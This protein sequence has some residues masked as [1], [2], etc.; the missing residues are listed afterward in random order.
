MAIL[1]IDNVK[2]GMV[3]MES[4]RNHQEQLLLETGRRITEKSIR[5]FKSWGVR[6]VAVTFGPGADGQEEGFAVGG[7]PAAIDEELRA[8]F[9]DVL[10]D[11]LM[12]E[13]MQAAGRQLAAR[14]PKKKI[15][16]GRG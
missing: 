1:N 9:A 10:I 11:P 12:V 14:Q 3:L 7:P 15:G 4:V 16:H 2:P 8:R 13:I 6:R 5:I